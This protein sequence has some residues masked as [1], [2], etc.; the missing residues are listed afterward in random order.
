MKKKKIIAITGNI[1][2]GKSKV[3]D[4][5][6][7]KLNMDT[8]SASKSFR[9][10]ARVHNMDITTFNEYIEKNP[11]IDSKIDNAMIEYLQNHDNLVMDSRLAWFFEKDAFK[12]FV[13][14]DLEVAAKRLVLD[15]INRNIEDKYNT[16]DEAKI[17]IIKRQNYEKDRYKKEYGIDILDYSNYDLVVD[18]TNLSVDEITKII[19]EKY[20]EWLQK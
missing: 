2:G 9:E 18:S 8:Y 12:V 13:T 20:K 17:A 16:I 19:I 5:I 10:L 4:A 6:A 11:E 7:K 1:A 15:S 3:V 14:V